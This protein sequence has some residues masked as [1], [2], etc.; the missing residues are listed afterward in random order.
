[1]EKCGWKTREKDVR[2]SI[3]LRL[4]EVMAIGNITLTG[5]WNPEIQTGHPLWE[6]LQLSQSFTP[7]IL[8]E[9]HLGNFYLDNKMG[10]F[11]YLN[12]YLEVLLS[13]EVR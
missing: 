6:A 3:S 12:N 11:N 2:F 7:E 9:E 1:M 13:L 10:Q 8:T 5:T 4:A